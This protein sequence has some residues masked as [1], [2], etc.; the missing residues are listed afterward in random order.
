MRGDGGGGKREQR[1][2][3][4]ERQALVKS[5]MRDREPT[6]VLYE[7]QGNAKSYGP[8]SHIL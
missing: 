4:G 1:A 5:E 3:A 7:S 6:V 2:K 8:M